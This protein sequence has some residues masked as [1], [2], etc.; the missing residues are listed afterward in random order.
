MTS[1]PPSAGVGPAAGDTSPLVELDKLISCSAGTSATF[2]VF[3]THRGATSANLRIT[4]LGLD[5]RWVPPPLPVG[6]IEP[7]ET[8]R[9]TLSLVPERGTLGAKYPFVVAAEATPVGGNGQPVMGVAESTLAVD[10]RDPISMT[11]TP[12]SAVAVFSQRVRVQITNPGRFDREL[13]LTASAARGASLSLSSTMVT[14]PAGRT[15]SVPGRVR[16]T[17]PRLIG[18]QSTHTFAVAARG[19]GAPEF[20]EGTLRSRPLMGGRMTGLLIAGLVIAIWATAAVVG[21]PKLSNYLSTKSTQTAESTTQLAPGAANATSAGAAPGAGGT[22]STSGAGGAGPSGATGASGS[23]G[24]GSGGAGGAG[25]SNGAAAGGAPPGASSAADGQL[26]GTVTG[27]APKGVQVSLEPTSL[28]EASGVGA[29]PAAGATDK[30]TANALRSISDGPIGK[31]PADAVRIAPAATDSGIRSTKSAADGSFSFAGITAPGYYLLT[32]AKPGFATQRFVINAATLDAATPIKVALV[33]GNG[34]LSGNVTSASGAVGAASVTITDGTVA[35]QT[36]TVS[37]GTVGKKPGSWT[38]SGLSTPGTYLVKVNATG[39]GEA[40]TL[41]TL[42]A[43]GTGKADLTLKTGVAAIDGLVTG[44]DGLGHLGPVGGVTVSA[45]GTSRGVAATRTATTVTSGPVG[46]FVLPDLP[47]PGTYTVTVSGP[48][49]ASQTR[50]VTLAEGSSSATVNVSLTRA[51]GTVSGT[52]VGDGKEGGLIG[53]GLTLTGSQVSYKTMTASAPAGAFRF[54]GVPPGTYVLQASQYGRVPSSATVVVTAA[55]S[56][57]V[58]LHLVGAPNTELPDT[59]HIRGRAVDSRTQGPLTCDRAATTV[60][61]ANCVVT[62]TTQV[63][64]DASKGTSAAP[65]RSRRSP[66]RSATTRCRVCTTPN[67]PDWSRAST[68]SRCR[69]PATNR[70]RSACR[71]RRVRRSP[72]HRSACRRSD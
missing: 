42:A 6:P 47:T 66:T 61:P 5:G 12:Q 4:V 68:R 20:M 22:G 45:S 62:A 15:V 40:S 43:G 46:T 39:Y 48:G 55:G 69:R 26:S 44:V 18:H 16:V 32:L 60:A 33:P 37:Q 53:A 57:T 58:N 35:L 63:P 70:R 36:S 7:G 56:A 28:V 3:V 25:G 14:V 72:P 1:L 8:T 54:T 23:G 52:V 21:I 59:S 71:S 65:N 29:Q 49:Y 2:E 38:V 41:V 10:S 11:L 64:L 27:T 67:I 34:S 9:I 30:A 31:V 17:H 50:E 13:S 24:S 19:L 51:D